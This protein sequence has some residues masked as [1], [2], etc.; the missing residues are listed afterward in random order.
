MQLMK[1]FLSKLSNAHLIWDLSW[2]VHTPIIVLISRELTKNGVM[3]GKAKVSV[4]ALQQSP[5]RMYPYFVFAGC[6]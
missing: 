1:S 3:S 5:L 2:A 4:M 6:P